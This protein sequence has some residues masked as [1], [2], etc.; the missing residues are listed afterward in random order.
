MQIVESDNNG[1]E[2]GYGVYLNAIG[3]DGIIYASVCLNKNAT[4]TQ[5]KRQ[6]RNVLSRGRRAYNKR[7]DE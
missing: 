5:I 7:N 1:R 3:D 6:R 4:E 2:Y